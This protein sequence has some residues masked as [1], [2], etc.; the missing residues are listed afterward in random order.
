MEHEDL[1]THL[2]AYGGEW[3]WDDIQ[4]P[5]GTDW[6]AEAMKNGTLTSVTDGSYME[7]L[8]WNISGTG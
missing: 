5:D 2:R 7:H 1:L 6:L 3:F 4:M 8:N